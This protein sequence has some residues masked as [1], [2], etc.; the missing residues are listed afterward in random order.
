MKGG[1]H[2]GIV[3]AKLSLKNPRKPKLAPVHVDALAD[4]GAVHLCIP[5]HISIQL[6]LEES[7]KK[8]VFLAEFRKLESLM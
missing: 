1:R 2:M 4:S 3:N 5:E 6:Q 7:G 8:E